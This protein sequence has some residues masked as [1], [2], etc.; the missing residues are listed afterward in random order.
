VAS[1]PPLSANAAESDLRSRRWMIAGLASVLA[2]IAGVSAAQL[3]LGNGLAVALLAGIVVATVVWLAPWTGVVALV[4]AATLIEQFSLVSE[5]TFS[6]GTDRLVLFQSLNTGAGL[7]GIYAT[8]FEMFLALLVG[9]WLIKGF[10]TRNLRLPRSAL[11]TAVAA[12]ALLVGLGWV[13]GVTGGGSFQDSLLELRPWLYMTIAFIAAS[14][15]LTSRK[16]VMILLTVLALGIGV[17]AM[18]GVVTLLTHFAARPQAILAH[19]ESFFFGLFLAVLAALWLIPIPGGLRRVMTVLSPVVLVAD[20]GNQRRTAWAIA[21][22]VLFAIF[23]LC[24][25]AFPERRRTILVLA[26]IGCVVAGVYWLKFSNDPGLLGQP[27]RAVLSQLAPQAR[28]QQS[29]QYRTVENVNLGIA[30]RQSTP[31]GTGFGHPIPQAVPNVDISNIDSF[32]SYLPHN[33]VLY[34]WLRL[35]LPGILAFWMMVGIGLMT[36]TNLIRRRPNRVVLLLGITLTVALVA[37]VVQG[38]YD[39]GLYW[40][41]IAIV[42]G[43]LMGAA[44]AASRFEKDERAAVEPGVTQSIDRE[45][46][47]PRLRSAA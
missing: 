45:A 7:R 6:D 20:I 37:Y 21:A 35:G 16:H 11:A 5:G 40:F 26:A 46:R 3:I 4:L 12:F 28:D 1:V 9:V 8:P 17:K 25:W 42:I 2:A 29:N 47:K 44:Q 22:A 27:A 38:F 14:Q 18:Q 34:V 32:I 19:E 39:M 31:L 24:F 30:I 15:L 10:A 41:R 13:R 43:C 33:G 36:G 23:A